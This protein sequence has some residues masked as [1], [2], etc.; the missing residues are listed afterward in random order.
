MKFTSLALLGKIPQYYGP[1][2]P[3]QSFGGLANASFKVLFELK[4]VLLL[5][6][7]SAFV[8]TYEVRCDY[9]TLPYNMKCF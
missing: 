5:G 9:V 3:I 4:T 2:K 7:L 6:V 8:C 1:K